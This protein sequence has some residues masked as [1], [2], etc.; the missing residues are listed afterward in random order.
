MVKRII[1]CLLTVIFMLGCVACA[2]V[3]EDAPDGMISVTCEG[4]PFKLYV[5]ESWTDN[6]A[7]GISSGY[8]SSVD[9]LSVSARYFTPDAKIG[10]EQYMK[11]CAKS[12]SEYYA[13]S[14]Y[15]EVELAGGTTLDGK[16]ALRNV[17]EIDLDKTRLT[18]FQITVEH[19]GDL[20]SL[21]GYCP[22]A[23]YESRKGEFDT[24]KS[25]FKLSE[26]KA[27]K[28][29]PVVD[30]NTPEGMQL[31]SNKDIEYRFYVPTSW[32]CNSESN[33]SEAY[34]SE[35]ERSNVTVTSYTLESS[36]TSAK[37]YFEDYL[38]PS[39]KKEFGKDYSRT[40]EPEART[41]GEREALCYTYTVT[42]YG[43][44]IKIMQTVIR[45]SGDNT[46]Y[47]ITYTAR[48]EKFDTHIKDVY[49]MLDSFTFR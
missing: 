47:T 30:K 21:Y 8:Y 31:A 39:Y 23:E 11:D 3:K 24:I 36:K 10:A 48:A 25:N 32:I 14:N 1:A 18:C 42:K 45:H 7:S 2:N 40:S 43:A 28:H 5:P 38:E 13:T 16:N 12:V 4:E 29:E 37:E 26:R 46:Y 6:R 19:K 41:V 27:V 44:E 49:K 17:Y 33:I 20:I 34:Y 22:K 9:H 35:S 15:K